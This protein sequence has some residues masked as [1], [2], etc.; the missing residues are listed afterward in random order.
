MIA[1]ILSNLARDGFA[2]I[3]RLHEGESSLPALS[4]LGEVV[5]LPHVEDVQVL[6]PRATSE[7]P[8][9]IYSGNFGLNAFPL[10]SDLA[11]WYLP[12]RYFALRC[13]VGA[14]AVQT[15]LFDG[16]SL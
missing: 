2:L 10:H 1:K 14:D 16:R 9:N 3:P 6:R 13:V 5:R 11:H 15:L 7:S 4:R 12:P 8:P